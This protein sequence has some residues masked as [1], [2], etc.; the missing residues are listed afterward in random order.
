MRNRSLKY[1][2]I[3]EILEKGKKDGKV[4]RADAYLIVEALH[5]PN[6]PTIILSRDNHI[7]ELAKEATRE[8]LAKIMVYS[9]PE[10]I[11]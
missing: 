5:H 9:K 7:K 1:S 10:F 11:Y 6:R 4:L 3:D 2:D 8:K